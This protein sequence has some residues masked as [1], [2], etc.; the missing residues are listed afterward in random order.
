MLCVNARAQRERQRLGQPQN[1]KGS[2]K[3]R[4]NGKHIWDD[5]KETERQLEKERI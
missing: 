3:K 1:Y 5:N 2:I 4:K